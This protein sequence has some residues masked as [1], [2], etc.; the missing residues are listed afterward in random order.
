[1][2]KNFW[3]GKKVFD[4]IEGNFAFEQEPMKKLTKA[5]EVMAYRHE[6]FWYCMDTLRDKMKLEEMWKTGAPWKVWN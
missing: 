2:D 3:N 6:G 5:G 1:M 4:Y